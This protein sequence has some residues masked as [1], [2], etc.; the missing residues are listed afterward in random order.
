MNI[1]TSPLTTLRVFACKGPFLSSE[2]DEKFLESVRK[3]KELHDMSNKKYIDNVWKEI[4]WGNIGEW[5][6]K[7][8]KF[9]YSFIAYF[10]FTIILLIT[11]VITINK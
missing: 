8:G 4:F 3:C 1:L 5:L 10:E 11:E 6:K 7:S 2:M 9:R